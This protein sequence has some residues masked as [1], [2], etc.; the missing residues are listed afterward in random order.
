MSL[1]AF[2]RSLLE[3]VERAEV[4]RELRGAYDLLGKDRGEAGAEPFFETQAEVVR[5]G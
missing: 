3:E 5:R 1:N 2:V 4:D